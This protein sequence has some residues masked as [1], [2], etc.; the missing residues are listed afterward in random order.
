M[1]AERIFRTTAKAGI[2]DAVELLYVIHTNA[3]GEIDGNSIISL[4][5]YDQG[6][7]AFEGEERHVI[8]L[9]EEPKL[10]I[11]TEC[12]MRTMT[13]NGIVICTFTPMQGMSDTVL[14]YLEDGR[15]PSDS[16]SG[17]SATAGLAS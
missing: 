12:L 5:S 4:K 16:S 3:E 15:L 6:R 7:V 10:D 14:L 9:D 2:Q 11:Y 1:P 8:W 13:T 17:L